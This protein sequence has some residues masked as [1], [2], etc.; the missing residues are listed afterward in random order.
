MDYNIFL[1]GEYQDQD[2]GFHKILDFNCK[3]DY[4]LFRILVDIGNYRFGDAAVP[5]KI[6]PQN[7]DVQEWKKYLNGI[8]ATHDNE[9]F[10]YF[11]PLREF[12]NFNWDK[13]INYAIDGKEELIGKTYA[14]AA[15]DFY[16]SFLPQLEAATAMYSNIYVTFILRVIIREGKTTIIKPDGNKI[17]K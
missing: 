9:I 5:N 15:G 10:I 12:K 7:F 3:K 16:S 1:S 8:N 17:I 14:E 11:L 2:E 6:F 4:K 13:K